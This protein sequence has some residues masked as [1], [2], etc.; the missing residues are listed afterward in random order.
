MTPTPPDS[1]RRP[2]WSHRT[3]PFLV[4][5]TAILAAR[6]LLLMLDQQILAQ[7]AAIALFAVTIATVVGQDRI[8]DERERLI[9]LRA[10][11]QA[12]TSGL[13]LVVVA[14]SVLWWRYWRRPECVIEA[15]TLVELGVWACAVAL[16]GR[17][18]RIQTERDRDLDAGQP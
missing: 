5:G 1:D 4:V 18:L 7:V 12:L 17:A 2:P 6:Y 13:G 9:A 3:A 14:G 11:A 8:A 10:T 15:T 16:Y